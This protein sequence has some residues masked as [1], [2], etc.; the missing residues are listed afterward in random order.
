MGTIHNNGLLRI[1][2]NGLRNM[3]NMGTI[4]N[5]DLLR[6]LM[7]NMDGYNT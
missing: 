2:N 1:P 7:S 3:S 4:H 5:N 6:I